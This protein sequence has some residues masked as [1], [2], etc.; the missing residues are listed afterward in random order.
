M[1]VWIYIEAG[2]EDPEI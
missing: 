1:D 2:Y